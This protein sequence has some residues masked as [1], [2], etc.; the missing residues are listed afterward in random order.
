M[1]EFV[2]EVGVFRAGITQGGDESDEPRSVA[3]QRLQRGPG[4][5]RR[6][7]RRRVRVLIYARGLE[8]RADVRGERVVGVYEEEGDDFVF[9][10]VHPGFYFG[11]P[12]GEGPGVEELAVG[13]AETPLIG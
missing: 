13:V 12:G 6:R 4:L 11:Q 10:G 7:G 5:H 9:V 2:E 8:L 3:D 1:C